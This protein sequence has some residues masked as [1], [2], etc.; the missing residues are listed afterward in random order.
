VTTPEELLEVCRAAVQR[1]RALGA[2]AV[3]VYGRATREARVHVENNDLGTALAHDEEA[4]GIRVR[5]SG[6]TGFASSNDRS[7]EALQ[8]AA[9]AALSLARVAP[10]DPDDELPEPAETSEVEGLWDAELADL[11]VGA[12]G[13]LTGEL[14][15]DACA[16]DPRVRLDSGWVSAVD[17]SRAIATST[18]IERGERSTGAD[19]LLFGMAA[20]GDQVGSFDMDE[21]QVCS[22]ATLQKELPVVPERFVRRVLRNL[23]ASQGESFVGTLVLTPEAVAEFLLPN[24][25]AAMTATAVRTG[26]SPFRDKIG[27][28]VFS[29]ALTVT[30]DGTLPGRPGSEGF[31]REGVSHRPLALVAGGEL[32]S[33]LFHTR[34]A[35][36]AGHAAGSTGHASGGS[37]AP[38]GIGPT[39][40]IVDAGEQ[41]EARLLD[42]IERGILLSRF[43][44]NSDPVSGDFSGVAK[45]S[46]LLRR[47]E[48]PKPVQETLIAGNL[49]ELLDSVSAVGRE[50]RWIGGTVHTPHVRL[51]GVSVTAG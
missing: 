41:D 45:G 47:G 14:V 8:E 7:P 49:Y 10:A 31:D 11:D 24:L 2:D 32:R 29:E 42:D 40:L 39:N 12:V 23:Q 43:S 13:R 34:E 1:S 4:F 50:R 18:G 46:L 9:R 22:L 21:A 6:A 20:E 38:P 44:G 36:A 27:S 51:E 5:R 28:R 30:D 35:R 33:F 19:V 25:V 37:S 17:H 48:E 3:E 15:R 26:R 16:R